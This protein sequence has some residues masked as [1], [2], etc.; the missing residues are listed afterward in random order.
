MS[1]VVVTTW[2]PTAVAPSRGSFVVRDTHA[3]ALHE[4]VRLVHLV[5]P[6]DDDGTRRLVHEGIDVLRIPMDPRRPDQVLRAAGQLRRALRGAGLVHSM[7]FSAL[8]PLAVHRPRC[9]WVHTEHWSALTTPET[10]PALA[11]LGLPALSQLLRM[12]DRVTA[13]CE[14]LARPLRAV[15]GDRPTD[16]VPCIVEPGPVTPR[17]NRADGTLRLVSTGG[18]IPRKDPLI[19]VETLARLVEDGVDARLEWLGDGPLR[20]ETLARAQQLGV[21]ERLELPGTVDGAGV[22]A[23]LARSDLFFGP[24]RADNFFV[25]AAEAIVSG[26]PV[27]LGA[28]GGQGEYVREEVGA[29]V[30]VQDAAAYAAAIR[31]VDA[32]TRSLDAQRIADTIGDA[33]SSSTVGEGYARVHRLTRAGDADLP[34]RP[35]VEGTAPADGRTDPRPSLL[36]MSFSD[37]S[38]DARVLKQVR[39]LSTEYQVLTCG[40]GPAPEGST[41]HLR[42]PEELKQWRLDKPLVL[43]RR[44]RRVYWEQEVVAW[45]AAQGLP[46]TDVV[47]ADDVDTVPLA[48]SLAPRGGV[49]ADLHE[50]APRQKEDRLDWRLVVAPYLRWIC[51]TYVTRADSVTTVGRGLAAEYLREF[52]IR[53]EVVT[54]AA[55]YQE[56]TPSRTGRPLRIV[57]SGG[58]MP[59]RRLDLMITAMGEA[60][61]DATLDLYLVPSDPGYV[62]RLREQAAQLPEGRVRVHDA[63]PYGELHAVLNGYDV[64]V[65]VCPPTTFN[66]ANALP[67][68]VFDFVQARLALVVSPTPEMRDLVA[69]HDLGAVTAGFDAADLARTL[70]ALDVDAVRAAK[71]SS[72]RHARELSA[73]QQST[74]WETAVRALAERSGHGRTD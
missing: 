24:T 56:L 5:P 66:L 3:L 28:T 15:R 33:F 11:R 73:E 31:D 65:F 19:A 61:L 72:D 39:M 59:S 47:L 23:A 12:P 58:A 37:I 7:A 16:V 63:V 27:V 62:D 36:V 57:H 10:L 35:V 1:V 64:G 60:D 29:L 21:A 22:R 13:V 48:L 54:N 44:Y 46:R 2:F 14:F 41:W 9:P 40:Y 52:G 17:R 55:P 67:N 26:R 49:H 38:R 30:E 4:D 53:A 50:Y 70:R 74:A 34:V 18:L 8:L 68:K 25:S 6:R 42:I 43:A 69:D 32:R 20:E 45:V 71:A 51:R